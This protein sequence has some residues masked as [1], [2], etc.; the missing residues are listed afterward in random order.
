MDVKEVVSLFINN[1]AAVALLIYFI[2]KD[3]KFTTQI[4]NSLTAINESLFIIRDLL[5][6]KGGVKK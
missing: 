3:N 6:T 1:G 4:N 5:T 2:Y